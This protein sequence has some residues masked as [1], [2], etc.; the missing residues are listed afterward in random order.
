MGGGGGYYG[1]VL[2]AVSTFNRVD[3]RNLGALHSCSAENLPSRQKLC[4]RC[5]LLISTRQPITWVTVLGG[6][7]IACFSSPYLVFCI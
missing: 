4:K 5:V 1:D 7:H 6:G 3:T 2:S